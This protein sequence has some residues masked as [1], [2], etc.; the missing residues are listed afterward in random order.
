MFGTFEKLRAEFHQTFSRRSP[1]L[2]GSDV[3]RAPRCSRWQGS[4]QAC[5]TAAVPAVRADPGIF[6]FLI[7]L[8]M[9][10][11]QKK[12][13]EF[14]DVAQGRTTRSSR[15]AASTGR[16][17]RV[18]DKTVQLQIADKVRIE[19]AR[20]AVGG[21]QGQEPVVTDRAAACRAIMNKNL[22]WKILTVIGVF[23]V[24]FALGVYPLLA[25]QYNLPLPGWLQGQAFKLGLDLQGRRP[26]G[27]AGAHRR[28]AADVDDDDRANSC[29]SRWQTAGVTSSPSRPSPTTFRVEGVPPGP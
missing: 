26:P 4:G 27:A 12:V 20:R 5:W 10:R 29:A 25:N 17:P 11:R 22:R 6:Y 1:I 18:S 7:L 14:Q 13:Q 3:R 16:S 9:Q 2:N 8:P 24:F 21:Y 15:R 23:V 28:R 19:V